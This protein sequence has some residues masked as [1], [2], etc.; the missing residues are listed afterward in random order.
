MNQSLNPYAAPKAQ[1]RDTADGPIAEPF[2]FAV[3]RFKLVLMTFG[4]FNLYLFYWFYKNWKYVQWRGEE[5]NAPVRTFFYSLTAYWLFRHVR[6]A[7]RD[8]D[9]GGTLPAGVLAIIVLLLS[10]IGAFP[11]PYFLVSLLSILPI[12]RVQSAVD[13]INLRKTPE[14]DAN[15]R[16][17]A[18]NYVWLVFG[19]IFY[20]LMII[21]LVMGPQVS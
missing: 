5:L 3:S 16:L 7:L 13:E 11:E 1:L 2:F 4:T 14:A 6:S 19:G 12:L 15:D 18:W 21:G 20:L 8:V 17:T 10:I 9:A